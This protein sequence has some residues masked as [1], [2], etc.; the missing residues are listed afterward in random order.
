MRR[1][2][3]GVA[4][5]PS[6]ITMPGIPKPYPSIL[7]F[8]IARF[9]K[10]SP[11]EWEDRLRQGKILD[12]DGTPVTKETEYV[13]LRRLFYFREVQAER[14]I[15]FIEEIVFQNEDLLVACKPHFLPVV[16]AGRF[17]EECL[18]HRLR[19]GSGNG[20]LTPIHRIDRDT[21]GIVLF[22]TNKK[23]RG[24]YSDLFQQNKIRKTYQALAELT[25]HP[26]RRKWV[27]ENRLKKGEPWFRMKAVAGAPNSQSTIRLV[28]TKGSIAR[29]LLQPVTGKKHQ[30]RIHMC[31]L[32]FKIMNDRYYPDL[33]PEQ[34]DDYARPLQLIAQ[35]VEFQNPLT[36]KK[37]KFE[38]HR[39]FS[40]W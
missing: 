9:P 1:K 12:E 36:G 10:V 21:A 7:S 16:P 8:L 28:E 13:P 34:E 35:M 11:Q 26:S 3:M 5:Y 17:V 20:D 15:P 18:L 31:E 37:M 14:V 39:K 27:V 4:R 23:T 6:V 25:H 33:L 22:S 32:G 38:S 30:L 2:S 24:L 40:Q 29:F 19:A